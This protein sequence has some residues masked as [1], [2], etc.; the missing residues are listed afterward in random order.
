MVKWESTKKGII[1]KKLEFAIVAP[2]ALALLFAVGCGDKSPDSSGG[3][4]VEK[5]DFGVSPDIKERD[6]KVEIETEKPAG[7]LP[8]K[9]DPTAGAA[10]GALQKEGA[11]EAAEGE[12]KEGEAAEGEAKEAEEEVAL[13]LADGDKVYFG[14]CLRQSARTREAEK[15][16]PS[17]GP[18]KDEVTVEHSDGK[19]T[20]VH[21]LTHNCCHKA[22]VTTKKDG[23]KITVKESLDGQD[24]RCL[25]ESTIK[26]EVNLT[27]KMNWK[28]F[29]IKVEVDIKGEPGPSH[30]KTLTL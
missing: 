5:A 11:P 29:I 15:P 9:D 19:I 30:E 10:E 13:A 1:M 27:S 26:T 16:K 8:K 17:S 22:K 3:A 23:N 2:M 24:C 12:V 25:C 28:E 7:D 14:G 21:N 20:V 4:E 18:P 6:S